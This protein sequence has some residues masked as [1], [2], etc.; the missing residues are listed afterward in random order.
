MKKASELGMAIICPDT[1]PRGISI[2]GDSTSYDF[3]TGASFYVDATVS[4]WAPYQMYSYITKELFDLVI[5]SLPIDKG[6]CSISGHSMVLY[7]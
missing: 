2:E 6:N 7:T 1:S 4:K 3:G 5:E